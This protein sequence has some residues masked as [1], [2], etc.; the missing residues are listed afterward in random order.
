MILFLKANLAPLLDVFHL[1]QHTS[2]SP[3]LADRLLVQLVVHLLSHFV[4][5]ATARAYTGPGNRSKERLLYV[6]GHMWTDRRQ[7]QAKSD[8][9]PCSTRLSQPTD[10]NPDLL[11]TV[12]P[13]VS[14]A[15]K[16]QHTVQAIFRQHPNANTHS[17]TITSN[18]ILPHT[19]APSWEVA[20]VSPCAFASTPSQ[21]QLACA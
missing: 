17:L 2:A 3:S 11:S 21:V 20:Y 19:H 4:L 12:H 6:C 15:G 9:I 10:C 18:T 5:P 16:Q 14:S 1:P 13:S 8:I 7:L